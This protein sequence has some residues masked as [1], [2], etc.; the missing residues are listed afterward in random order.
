MTEKIQNKTKVT[1]T[2]EATRCQSSFLIINQP[3][4]PKPKIMLIH[5]PRVPDEIFK[6]KT[7]QRKI[8]IA[9]NFFRLIFFP[10]RKLKYSF[11]GIIFLPR[12]PFNK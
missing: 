12:S 8:N 6:N 2:V 1:K 10:I 9:E 7:K 5:I 4:A 3:T 11:K